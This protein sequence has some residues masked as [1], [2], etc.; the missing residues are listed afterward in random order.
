MHCLISKIL[1]LV[2]GILRNSFNCSFQKYFLLILSSLL[3]AAEQGKT[4]YHWVS[5][6]TEHFSALLQAILLGQSHWSLASHTKRQVAHYCLE[7]VAGK[8]LS[9]HRLDRNNTAWRRI[10]WHIFHFT[11]LSI[12]LP[13]LKL[14]CHCKSTLQI[15]IVSWVEDNSTQH[16]QHMHSFRVLSSLQTFLTPSEGWRFLAF[17]EQWVEASVKSKDL[18]RG[19]KFQC[20]SKFCNIPKPE[21]RTWCHPY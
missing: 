11:Q 5:L 4:S 16:R 19:T 3:F 14:L 2:H 13:R 8:T 12:R 15:H 21:S 17:L 1:K 18:T 6:C 9:G 10:Y 20:H 7:R